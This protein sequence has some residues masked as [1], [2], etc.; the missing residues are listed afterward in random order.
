MRV[1]RVLL[2]AHRAELGQE[3]VGETSLDEEPQPRARIL[4]QQQ[5]RQLVA[6]SLGTDD[7]EPLPELPDRAHQLG[8]GREVEV[9]D[10]PC[11]AEHAERIVEEGDLGLERRAQ[12]P[13]RE[14]G[15]AAVRIDQ[16]GV[17]QP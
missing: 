9:G 5:L 15:R 13:R 17:G 8:L 10:E 1:E 14:I 4:D 2:E 12:A 16:L 3:L 7:L 6:N 11:R